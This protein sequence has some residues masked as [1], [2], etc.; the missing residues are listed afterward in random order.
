MIT[1][2]LIYVSQIVFKLKR[3]LIWV[4]TNLN[5]WLKTFFLFW[6]SMNQPL[7]FRYLRILEISKHFIMYDSMLATSTLVF[8]KK[9]ASNLE[10]D[11]IS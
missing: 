5:V 1:S 4:Y 7:Y 6:V 9:V 10:K 8:N 2:K 3:T 11:M